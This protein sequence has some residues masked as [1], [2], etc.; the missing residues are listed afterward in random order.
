MLHKHPSR[1]SVHKAGFPRRE[2]RPGHQT[3]TRRISWI[4]VFFFVAAGA[5]VSRLFLL[6]IVQHRAYAALAAKQQIVV[7]RVT[8]ERGNIFAQDRSGALVPL[9]L[10]RTVST[11]AAAPNRIADL[12]AVAEFAAKEFGLPVDETLEKISSRDDPYTVLVRG[13]DTERAE[14]LSIKKPEGLF[15][16]EERRRAY[17]HGALA[18][19]LLGFVSKEVDGEVGKY[20][21]ERAYNRDLAGEKGVFES[22]REAGSVW[23]A[24]GKRIF[25]PP[26]HGSAIVLT[27]DPTIQRKA[28]EVL[29]SA[30]KKWSPRSAAVLV[31]DP[32]TGKILALAALPAFHPGEFSKE[33]D[34]SV[35]LN[36]LAE[37]SYELGSVLKPVTVASALE[38]GVVTPEST[39][40]D[41][42]LAQVG[43]HAIRNFDGKAYGLRSVSE[44]IE[45]S[46]N[47][48]AV[49]VA[50]LL[51]KEKQYEYLTRFG[52]GAKTGVDLPGEVSGSIEHL[53]R[54]RDIDFATASFGQGIAV[55]PLQLASAIGVIANR[56]N[57]MRPYAVEKIIDDS[58]NE[59]KRGPEV[60]RRVVSEKTAEE[61]TRMMVAAVRNGF[62][63]RAGVKGYFVAAKTGTA[64]VPR[65]DGR[66]Y[67][68]EVTHTFVGYAPAFRP[69]FLILLQL[70]EPT[71]NRF[72]ANTLTPAFHDLSEFIL[73]YYEV[74]PDEK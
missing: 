28:E 70:N 51:G 44:I 72:A 25:R 9:A 39:Y 35:F 41:T 55:T 52:F 15:F 64:Q 7:T 4:L 8:P 40:T 43:A 47:V 73:N 74:P 31:I 26:L 62:E 18:A 2:N 22:I 42:G 19:H 67:S 24:L 33:K 57:L 3:V 53:E 36:P 20:G 5:L 38:E 68:D 10:N 48:G 63:N 16:E 32:A 17:P 34:F 69:R 11:L 50:R 58:G 30:H 27:I 56:G 13:V 45:K 54:R 37:S 66:G 46:L 23:Y 12:Q 14:A 29:A 61:V 60:V 71:G 1:L 65:S 21:I 49:W 59:T 6:Q